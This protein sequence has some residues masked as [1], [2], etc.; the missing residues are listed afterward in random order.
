MG[1][2]K[3]VLLFDTGPTAT[4]WEANV[5]RLGIRLEL[6]DI[7][8]LSHWHKDHSGIQSLTQIH[9][10]LLITQGGMIRAVEMISAARKSVAKSAPVVVDLHPDRPAFRGFRTP[11]GIISL[12]ADPSFDELEVAGARVNTNAQTHVVGNGS[13]LI[14]GEIPRTTAYEVGLL[15][16][17]RFEHGKGWVEDEMIRDER[18]V[19]CNLKG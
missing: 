8:V 14:S 12:Q 10:Y 3:S 9:F 18:F 2:S 7:I 19:M 17:M 15:R 4:I 1:D 16:G 11:M 13:F 5:R 6:I